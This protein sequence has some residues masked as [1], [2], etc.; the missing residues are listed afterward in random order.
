MVFTVNLDNISKHFK[1]ALF[2]YDFTGVGKGEI[3]DKVRN[4]IDFMT[5]KYQI[6]NIKNDLYYIV[7]I[8]IYLKK[9]NISY[10][11]RYKSDKKFIKD[12]HQA[13]K[14]YKFFSLDNVDIAE[15]KI[16]FI[17]NETLEEQSFLM[18]SIPLLK[19]F[20][21]DSKNKVDIHGRS[22]LDIFEIME[23]DF[24]LSRL[25]KTDYS[26]NM[27]NLALPTFNYLK[28]NTTLNDINIYNIAPKIE[29]SS[30]EFNNRTHKSFTV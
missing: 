11:Y 26:S 14:V 7:Y 13:I 25:K 21:S 17:N 10:P 30:I 19:Y 27:K 6:V 1:D 22:T 2:D 16:K 9:L 23:K 4:K 12:L 15:I 28:E 18:K 29:C 24:S 20:K 5:N 3:E 8:F